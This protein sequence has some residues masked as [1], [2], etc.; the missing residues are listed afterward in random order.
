M[1]KKTK[2]KVSGRKRPEERVPESDPAPPPKP[3]KASRPAP[4]ATVETE[5]GEQKLHSPW[6]PL[7]WLLIPLLACV[8]YGVATR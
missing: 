5:F 6:P 3:K 4:V 8:A 1:A 7:I 2:K